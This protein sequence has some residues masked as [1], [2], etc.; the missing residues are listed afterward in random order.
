[1]LPSPINHIQKLGASWPKNNTQ[2]KRKHYR[3]REYVSRLQ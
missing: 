2:S 3:V 1:M